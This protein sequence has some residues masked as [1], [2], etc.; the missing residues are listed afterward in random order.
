MPAPKFPTASELKPRLEQFSR[1]P[2]AYTAT[3]AMDPAVQYFACNSIFKTLSSIEPF[4][5]NALQDAYKKPEE[6][7]VTVDPHKLRELSPH[8]FGYLTRLACDREYFRSLFKGVD[9]GLQ[10]IVGYDTKDRIKAESKDKFLVC[11]LRHFVDLQGFYLTNHHDSYD[12]LL[13]YV[14]P[15]AYNSTTTSIFRDAPLNLNHVELDK[16][17]FK[18]Q[19]QFNSS[20]MYADMKDRNTVYSK[21][22]KDKNSEIQAMTATQFQLSYGEA[23]VIPNLLCRDLNVENSSLGVTTKISGHGVFPPVTEAYRP[24]LLID[25]MIWDKGK[26]KDDAKLIIRGNELLAN[27][28]PIG[29]VI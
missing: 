12:T 15:L 16:Y 3:G 23:I 13:A 22:V 21:T 28:G 19:A 26:I 9:E 6:K 27:L 25:Y 14:H 5:F 11:R 8:Y 2:L 1:V 7:R 18:Y 20:T 10:S 4:E 17:D 24:V 29:N